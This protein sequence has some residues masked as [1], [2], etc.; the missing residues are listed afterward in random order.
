MKHLLIFLSVI[1]IAGCSGLSSSKDVNL[2][3]ITELLEDIRITFIQA[4]LDGLM[5]HYHSDFFHNGDFFNDEYALWES[6]F[7][8][9]V[10]LTIENID[11]EINGN[12]AIAYFDLTFYTE[13]GSATWQEPSTE[14]GDLSYL[15]Y[16]DNEWQIYGNQ[17]DP[18]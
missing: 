8:E 14:L 13:S 5:S 7:V 1:L 17:I 2:S 15:F 4:D 3:L 18:N 16:D 9:Y 12:F 11:I 10:D 6:R